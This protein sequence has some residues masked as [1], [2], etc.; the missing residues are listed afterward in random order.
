MLE[1]LEFAESRVDGLVVGDVVAAFAPGAF[2]DGAEPDVVGG[3]GFGDVGEA[4]GD[5]AEIAEG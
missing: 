1:V 2:E 3:D 5:G 4:I